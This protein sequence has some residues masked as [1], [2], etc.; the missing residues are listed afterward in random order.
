MASPKAMKQAH[1]STG[2]AEMTPPCYDQRP[3]AAATAAF[4]TGIHLSFRYRRKSCLHSKRIETYNSCPSLNAS[5]SACRK[6]CLHSKRIETPRRPPRRFRLDPRR[7]SC[8]HSKRIET[9]WNLIRPAEDQEP[10]GSLAS[11]PRGLKHIRRPRFSTFPSRPG[12]KSCLHSKRIDGFR[13]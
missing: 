13:R 4:R 9:G 10:V 2:S 12:R 5:L 6:S 11:I 1:A 8:L 7:K 3:A